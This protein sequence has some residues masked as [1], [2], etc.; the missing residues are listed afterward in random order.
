MDIREAVAELRALASPRNVEGMARYGISSENTLGV[1]I[2]RIRALGKR[3]GCDHALA[4]QLWDT[5][6]HEARIMAAMVDD[7]KLVT[8][9]QMDRR[10]ADF[11]CSD[12]GVRAFSGAG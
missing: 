4:Q 9:G 7:P 10:A 12:I 6:I 8:K 2:P 3:A 5:G 11:G 1:S